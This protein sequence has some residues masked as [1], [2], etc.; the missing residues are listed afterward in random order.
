VAVLRYKIKDIPVEGLVVSRAIEPALLA[1][2]LEDS[3]AELERT[4]GAVDFELTRSHDDV[5]VSGRLKATIGMSCALCLAPTRVELDQ[6]IKMVYVREGADADDADDA[7]DEEDPLDEEDVGTHD[8]EHIDLAPMIREQLI[9]SV[10][11]SPRCSA[12]CKGL[13]PTCGQNLNE[14]DCGHERDIHLS[15]LGAELAKLN[16]KS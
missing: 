7:T 16:L 3:G 13:C 4:A 6:S 2:A 12:A 9:L 11:I 5:Y 15:P 10:P 1:D 8:G 14:A